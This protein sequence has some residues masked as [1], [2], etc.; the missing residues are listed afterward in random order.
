MQTLINI[1]FPA[2]CE[3]LCWFGVFV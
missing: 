1:A 3:W 2:L